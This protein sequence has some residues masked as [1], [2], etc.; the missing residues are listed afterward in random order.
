MWI[1]NLLYLT[2][3]IDILEM[4]VELIWSFIPILYV[5]FKNVEIQAIKNKSNIIWYK[6]DSS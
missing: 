6:V 2:V 1:F 4:I 5:K 3:K